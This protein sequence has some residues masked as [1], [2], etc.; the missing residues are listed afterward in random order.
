MTVFPTF[1]RLASAGFAALGAALL[2][3][4]M[5]SPGAFTSQL[6]LMKNGTFAYAYEGEI[7]LFG[8]SKLAE[9]S[10]PKP[11]LE[12][13][14]TPQPCYDDD[15]FED[16]ECT[17]EELAQQEIDWAEQRE[18][19]ERDRERETQMMRAM[20]GGID[21]SDPEAAQDLAARLERQAG[22]DSV[23]YLGDG[24]FAVSFRITGRLDHDFVFPTIEQMPMANSF[25]HVALRDGD[26]VRIDAPG[27]AAQSGTNP[28]QAMMFAGISEPF[29][30][31]GP[32]DESQPPLP[33]M[34][35]TFRIV[36]DG[37]ILANN[38]DAGPAEDGGRQVLE[39]QVDRRAQAAPMALIELD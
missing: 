24:E 16:R 28:M 29:T 13:E 34:K 22:W 19:R 14:Y 18:A 33:E 6:E 12:D 5:L 17:A 11:E 3:G 7:H 1:K 25:V 36:T 30:G 37:R 23:E 20:F 9:M 32:S 38:T 15:T 4:C 2:T 21:P 10:N 8:L 27:F 39:W 35:G 31:A 26:R